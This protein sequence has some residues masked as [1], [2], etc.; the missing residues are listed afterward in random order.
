[1]RHALDPCP[2][3]IKESQSQRAVFSC[4]TRCGRSRPRYREERLVSAQE[5]GMTN[6]ERLAETGLSNLFLAIG[7]VIVFVGGFL[8]ISGVGSALGIPVIL[9]GALFLWV[10]WKGRPRGKAS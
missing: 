9:A 5:V 4:R 10:G 8:A 2:R 7:A 6:W 3:R 1:M